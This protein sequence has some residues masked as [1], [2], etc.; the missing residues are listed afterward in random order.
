[1]KKNIFILSIVIS[2][3]LVGCNDS[4]MDRFPTDSLNDGTF[5][6]SDADLRGYVNAFYPI[7]FPG[8]GTRSAISPFFAGA[9]GGLINGDHQSDNMA[10]V[11]PNAVAAGNHPIPTAG[12]GWD[13]GNIRRANFFLMRYHR[14][15]V[16]PEVRNRYAAEVRL[17]RAMEY[18]RLVRRF[19]D[20]PWIGRDLTTTSPELFAPRDSRTLVMDSVMADIN[21]AIEHLPNATPAVVATRGRVNRDVALAFKARVALHEGTFR[22]YHGIPGYERFLREAISAAGRLMA[23]GNYSIHNTGNP[24]RDYRAVFS[25][26][27]LTANPISEVIFFRAYSAAL[28]ITTGLSN[29]LSTNFHNL[30]VTKSLVD[31]YLSRDGLPIS[32]SPLFQGHYNIFTEMIDRD[33]RLTQTVAGKHFPHMATAGSTEPTRPSI[34]GAVGGLGLSSTGYH[35]LKFWVEDGA[36]N[37]GMDNGAVDAPIFRFAETLLIYAEARAELGEADQAV[38]DRT[39]N[40]LRRRVGMPDMVIANLVRDPLSYFPEV[41]VLIDE[42]RRERRVELALEGFRYDDLMRWRAGRLLE[43]EV[44]GMRFDPAMFA[45]TNITASTDPSSDANII[46]NAD[47]FIRPYARSLR[48]GRVFR[49]YMYFFPLPTNELQLNPNLVQNPGWDR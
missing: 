34:P 12:G 26:P 9:G 4:F 25:T 18:F 41:D 29:H 11:T 33:P 3:L 37:L 1:M 42:I 22:K 16:A 40:L 13:W 48:D 30:G 10:P 20:V 47:G 49:D 15:P 27:N 35:V 21:W 19:G 24:Y 23:E 28:D 2:A 38:I 44:L 8:H 39:I 17:F 14:T 31:S 6:N 32:L 5:W 7:M 36:V 43:R 46:I 45:D